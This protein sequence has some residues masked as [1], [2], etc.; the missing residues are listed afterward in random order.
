[1]SD[2]KEITQAYEFKPGGYYIIEVLNR[3]GITK[4][5]W[6]NLASMLHDKNIYVQFIVTKGETFSVQPLPALPSKENK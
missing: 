1:M 5:D 2:I 3:S 6:H 4:D